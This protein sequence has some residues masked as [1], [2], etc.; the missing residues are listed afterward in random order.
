LSRY[1]ITDCN[2]C[3]V[4]ENPL[5]IVSPHRFS[6]Q[7]LASF[8]SDKTPAKWSIIEKLEAVP[9]SDEPDVHI[10]R[11]IFV[12]VGGM[13][14]DDILRMLHLDARPYLQQDVIAL[15]NLTHDQMNLSEMIDLGVRGFFF[16]NDQAEFMLKGICALKNGEMWVARGELMEYVCRRSRSAP[17]EKNVVNLLTKKEKQ[18]VLL[19]ASGASNAEISSALFIS[20][21]TVKTHIYHILKKLGVQNRLQAALWAS[22]N[23]S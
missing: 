21:H 22:K 2:L 7:V 14:N 9:L 18:V 23:L 13:S 6:A 4:R 12:D 19:L 16:E 5:I 1:R 8:I 11:L 20:P 3:T 17:A 10:W 15:F